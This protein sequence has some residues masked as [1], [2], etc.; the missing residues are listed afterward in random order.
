VDQHEYDGLMAAPEAELMD[1]LVRARLALASERERRQQAELE[2]SRLRGQVLV[3][4]C[5][6]GLLTAGRAA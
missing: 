2:V 1:Q 6:L 3:Y 4:E 5:T